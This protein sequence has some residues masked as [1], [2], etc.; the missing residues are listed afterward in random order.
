MTGVQPIV[1][2]V[3]LGELRQ[4][5]HGKIGIVTADQV[6]E[7]EGS[8]G[9]GDAVGFFV[10]LFFGYG[11]DEGVL[12]EG[13]VVVVGRTGGFVEGGVEDADFGGQVEFL[14]AGFG[15]DVLF[16]ADVDAG[17]LGDLER[18]PIGK[19]DGRCCAL[20]RESV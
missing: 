8:T 9:F 15:V 1:D 20:K 5:L 18:V 17:G 19:V 7:D 6:A 10:G 2:T 14:D 11:V 12:T 3:L 13:Q 4:F 16:V